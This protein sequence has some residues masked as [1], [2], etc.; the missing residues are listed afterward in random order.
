MNANSM[1]MY[2]IPSKNVISVSNMVRVKL[3]EAEVNIE[4]LMSVYGKNSKVAGSQS[5]LRY[6][7]RG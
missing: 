5:S 4:E 3:Q 7:K 2:Y 1:P 6:K